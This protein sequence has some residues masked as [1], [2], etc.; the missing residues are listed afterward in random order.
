MNQKNFE[1]FKKSLGKMSACVNVRM[2]KIMHM[3][4][5]VSVCEVCQLSNPGFS[6]QFLCL[7]SSFHSSRY[8]LRHIYGESFHE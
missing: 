4:M 7:T 5:K 8:F 3:P 6:G 2:S 1:N